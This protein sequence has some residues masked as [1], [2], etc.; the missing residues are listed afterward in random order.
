VRLQL[1]NLTKRLNRVRQ[2]FSPKELV[3]AC[4]LPENGFDEIAQRFYVEKKEERYFYYKDNG[5]NVLAIAHLD[6]VQTARHCSVSTVG[7]GSKIAFSPVLDDRLGVYIITSLL[8]KLGIKAD[9]LLTI[10]EEVGKSTASL[11][12]STWK[13]DTADL[14]KKQYNWMFQFDRA[15]TDVVMY[16]Y[17]NQASVKLLEA[18]GYKVGTGSNSDISKLDDMGCVG[19]NF[20]CGYDNYHSYRAFAWLDETFEMV[21]RF[22]KFYALHRGTMMEHT[23][24]STVSASSYSHY[25]GF[26]SESSQFKHYHG[27]RYYSDKEW[28]TKSVEIALA[29]VFLEKAVKSYELSIGNI[30]PTRFSEYGYWREMPATDD[31][32]AFSKW[33]PYHEYRNEITPKDKPKVAKEPIDEAGKMAYAMKQEDK[34]SKW[35]TI[36]I[37][38]YGYWVTRGTVQAYKAVDWSKLKGKKKPKP[39][40]AQQFTGTHLDPNISSLFGEDGERRDTIEK[41]LAQRKNFPNDGAD[42]Q[43]KECL[44]GHPLSVH[45]GGSRHTSCNN[46]KCNCRIFIDKDEP[47][48]TFIGGI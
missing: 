7:D 11:F 42:W 46:W 25:G 20:G 12:E 6:S 41:R 21:A 1:M 36:H 19:F 44:C 48:E 33:M 2:A 24:T 14:P 34:L 39:E 28:E 38:Q 32:S 31:K 40:S 4:A 22:T 35:N 30:E 15:G 8:P 47:T 18:V 9:V 3:A 29:Q 37:A 43:P 5:S 45:Y 16:Q 27:G 13:Q 23:R 10:G 26:G 17:R